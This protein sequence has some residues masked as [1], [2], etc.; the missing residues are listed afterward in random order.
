VAAAERRKGSRLNLALPTVVQGHAQGKPWRLM[1]TSVDTS[2]GG[3]SL[4]LP[5]AVLNGQVLRLSMPLPKSLRRYGLTDASYQVWGLVRH[6]EPEGSEFRVG[7]VFLGKSPPRGYEK[8]PE[9]QFLLATDPKPERKERRHWR[10]LDVFLNLRIRRPGGDW[11]QTVAENLSVGGA[12]VMTA[13]EAKR[14]EMLEVEE[15]GGDFR[16]TAT[17]RNFYQGP[18]GIPRLNLGF[19]TPAP[20]RLIPKGESLG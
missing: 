15:L 1:V 10:R 12:R 5:R 11:E 20:E 9:A 19:D 7:V 8:N 3:A 4:K 16:T 14:D 2:F 6:I 17:V 13:I 18:D